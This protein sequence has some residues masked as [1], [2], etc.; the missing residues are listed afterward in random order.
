MRPRMIGRYFAVF[1]F[2]FTTAMSTAYAT[3]VY[4]SPG[5]NDTS[6]NGTIASPYRT[7]PKGIAEA[8]TGDTVFALPG[9]YTGSIVMEDQ[10]AI[11]GSGFETT[12]IDGNGATAIVTAATALIEGF[13]IRDGETAILYDGNSSVSVKSNY[14]TECYYGIDGYIPFEEGPITPDIRNNIFE[15]I[16]WG[17]NLDEQAFANGGVNGTIENN[18]FISAVGAQFN[19]GIRYRMHK[20]IP[21]IRA[22]SISGCKTGIEFT[23]LTIFDQRKLLVS[24]NNVWDNGSNYWTEDSTDLTGF[25]NNI[26]E[27]PQYCDVASGNWGVYSTSPNAPENNACGILLGAKGVGC[28]AVCGDANGSGGISISDAVFVISYIF[29]GGPAPHPLSAGDANCSGGIS[30]SDAVYVINHIFGGGPAPCSSC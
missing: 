17:I 15:T 14:I 29:G 30:I 4:V 19:T 28:T 6:G 18:T 16:L 1:T 20:S 11:V 2:V 27:D 26:S 21:I 22:N 3:K 9:T 12:V 8:S 23:Y 24:C 7:I 25:Q 10:I 13:T 5:G